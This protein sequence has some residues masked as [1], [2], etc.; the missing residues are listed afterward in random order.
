LLG[1]SWL[2]ASAG[3]SKLTEDAI[4]AVARWYERPA[5]YCHALTGELVLDLYGEEGDS[6]ARARKRC[7]RR[8]RKERSPYKVVKVQELSQRRVVL[9]LRT[10]KHVGTYGLQLR[11]RWRI[12]AVSCCRPAS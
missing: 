5:K 4:A 9:T 3:A 2:P 1:A 6:V 12:I 10:K 7:A 11:K 8:A